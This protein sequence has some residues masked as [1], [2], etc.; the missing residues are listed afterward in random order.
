MKE[1]KKTTARDLSKK[2]MSNMPD[3]TEFKAMIIKIPTGL[4]KSM[5]RISE[6][7]ER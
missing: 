6:T 1:Q 5:E 7:L 4:K 2:D 3:D